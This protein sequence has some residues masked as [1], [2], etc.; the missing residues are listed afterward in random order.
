MPLVCPDCG[1]T[2][3]VIVSNIDTKPTA[4]NLDFRCGAG[5]RRSFTAMSREASS[6]ER[7]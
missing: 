7:E 6:H 3:E 1:P 4:R 5:G 2:A